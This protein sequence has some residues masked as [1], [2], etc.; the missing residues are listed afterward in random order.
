MSASYTTCRQLRAELGYVPLRPAIEAV[1]L[2]SGMSF[3]HAALPRF[4]AAMNHAPEARLRIAADARDGDPEADLLLHWMRAEGL[5]A[6]PYR[7]LSD[8]S[9]TRLQA[10]LAKDPQGFLWRADRPYPCSA[11]PHHWGFD[12]RWIAQRL[13]VSQGRLAQFRRKRR[14]SVAVLVGNGPSLNQTNLDALRDQDVYVTNYALE[15]P[16]LKS[17]ARGVAVTNYF[18]ASQAP[19]LF[20]MFEGW[21]AFPVWLSHVLPDSPNTLWLPAVGGDLFFGKDPMQAVA[22]H[23]TVSYFWLQ[24]LF[25]AGYQKIVLVGFDNSYTQP[26]GVKEGDLIVQE[27]ADKNHFD[28]SY[29]QGKTWQAADPDR[30]AQTYRLARDVYRASGREIVNATVG[31]QLE[32]FAR[33][34][35]QTALR[36]S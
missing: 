33:E 4:V 31:G 29:F 18:V 14:S 28:T 12:P 10:E 15:N 21:K 27:T 2:D 22:W 32:V 24:L 9:A 5:N 19:E 35:L 34:D 16:A 20:G 3:S 30:M 7:E 11:G 26:A 25:F 36:L 23:S 1:R 17:L 8:E 13:E 6:P